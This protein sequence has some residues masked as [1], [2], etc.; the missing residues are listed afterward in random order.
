MM[1]L[2]LLWTCVCLLIAAAA[3]AHS[4][5]HNPS[6]ASP[7]SSS[8]SPSW[9]S[10]PLSPPWLDADA[11]AAARLKLNSMTMT[12]DELVDRLSSELRQA[13]YV[14]DPL[15]DQDARDLY[16]RTR[17]NAH[18]L[19]ERLAAAESQS[20]SSHEEA[21]S[22]ARLVMTALRSAYKAHST[23]V[24]ELFRREQDCHT[25][26]L[27][28]DLG[29]CCSPHVP[30]SPSPSQA[31]A[32][33]RKSAK[34]PPKLNPACSLA[35][36]GAHTWHM[37]RDLLSSEFVQKHRAALDAF[38]PRTGL[39]PLQLA[40]N[41]RMHQAVLLLLQAGADVTLLTQDQY[42]QSLAQ[43]ALINRDIVSLSVL[44]ERGALAFE[45]VD[46]Y[47]RS[48]AAVARK[49]Q[50]W[51]G[52]A[53]IQH[54]SASKTCPW[55]AHALTSPWTSTGA[56]FTQCPI[57]GY[58]LFL[59]LPETVMQRQK[60]AAKPRV[61]ADRENESGWR[62]PEASVSALDP[63]LRNCPLKKV[64][65]S[66]LTAESFHRDF[67]SLRQPVF[68]SGLTE[69]WPRIWTDF[70]KRALFDK[71]GKVDLLVGD[72][73]YANLFGARSGLATIGE[74]YQYMDSD[75]ETTSTPYYAFDTEF[76]PQHFN[77]SDYMLPAAVPMF[78]NSLW[79]LEIRVHHSTTTAMRSM[80]KSLARNDGF[81]THPPM[82]SIQS[83]IPPL[84]SRSIRFGPTRWTC[85]GDTI[86]PSNVGSILEK[87]SLFHA[88][89]RT[90]PSMRKR[91]WVLHSNTTV[92]ARSR[93]QL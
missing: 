5:Q 43:I 52:L 51:D 55:A 45:P 85:L 41:M 91:E 59:N 84:G 16:D 83:N 26:V 71:H 23:R 11:L 18:V 28:T 57:E 69:S 36:R 76:L 12:T 74:F 2:G 81:C 22:V 1:K 46:A 73:P 42:R 50:L 47:N 68:I 38:D 80:H 93:S 72:I 54:Y 30:S 70:A 6:D 40:V 15:A 21:P 65:V 82:P 17:L 60:W 53:L 66:T 92:T 35:N 44:L 10:S 64:H 63:S 34:N 67:A 13:V 33:L 27:A 77:S 87:C 61:R 29:G 88:F 39:S 78:G 20:G 7:L 79:D 3:T 56:P 75:A 37:L 89:G 8:S 32:A 49:L 19:L 25:L 14:V 58:Q 48:A 9:V 24:K 90:Q 62:R 31:Q 4:D 86:S